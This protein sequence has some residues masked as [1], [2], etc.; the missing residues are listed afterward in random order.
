MKKIRPVLLLVDNR[1]RDVDA[2]LFVYHWL[3]YLG[4]PVILCNKNN[5]I[6]K[7]YA[8]SPSVIVISTA[9]SQY[10]QM[11]GELLDQVSKFS[12][13]VILPQ[14]GAIPDRKHAMNLYSGRY[15][16]GAYTRGV[17][18]IFIWGQTMAKWLA[19][20][21]IF[22]PSQIMV[23]GTPRFDAFY[24]RDPSKNKGKA[25]GFSTSHAHINCY[26]TSK[27]DNLLYHIDYRNELSDVGVY[28]NQ[29]KHWEDYIWYHCAIFRNECEW[30]K[31]CIKDLKTKVSIR[32]SP[33]ERV[34]GY[35]F[36]KIKYRK[37][38]EIRNN[39]FI[40]EWFKGLSFLIN[41]VSTAGV[42]ALACG[43]PVI[44]PI[45]LIGRRLTEHV[46]LEQLVNPYF[47]KFFWQPKD[48]TEIK[49]MIEQASNGKLP[50]S[51]ECS[52]SE[53][54]EYLVDY[55]DFPR[56]EPSGLTIAMEIG[57]LAESADTDLDCRVSSVKI[58]RIYHK[59]RYLSKYCYHVGKDIG[60]GSFKSK[61]RYY[62]YPWH[63]NDI[64]RTKVIWKQIKAKFT[65]ESK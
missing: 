62:Y 50:L 2:V 43:L 48:N 52:K 19:E 26:T 49:R 42:A 3:V 36:L 65:G 58:K 13:I 10:E 64:M 23:A 37:Q 22:E 47:L 57:R 40:F 7:S 32:P 18:R 21:G 27:V 15:E 31:Y 35:D 4:Y 34:E 6:D 45:R 17:S 39:Y 5:W 33:F 59:L 12:K 51:P 20:E 30:I 46:D 24:L 61:Q 53:L 11:Y 28:Y 60:D 29:G 25:A 38:I 14:E 9:I 63:Y 8:Y 55:Y 54:E 44:S 41:Y 56:K 16:A 1:A